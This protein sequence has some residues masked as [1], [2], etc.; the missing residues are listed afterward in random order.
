LLDPSLKK[1]IQDN[2]SLFLDSKGLS[3]RYGQK[4]MIAEIA[5]SLALIDENSHADQKIVTIEAG[6]TRQPLLD[7]GGRLYLLLGTP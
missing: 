2:Y 3:A 4:L 6:T 7:L 1:T 5:K